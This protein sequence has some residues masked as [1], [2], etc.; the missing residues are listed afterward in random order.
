[1]PEMRRREA[2]IGADGARK[3]ALGVGVP[4]LVTVRG[5]ERG[6]RFG[7]RAVDP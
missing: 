7:E 4:E 5:A 3:L 2:G 6:I 1:M